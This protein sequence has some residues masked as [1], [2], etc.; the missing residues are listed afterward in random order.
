M[1]KTGLEKRKD[2]R[3]VNQEQKARNRRGQKKTWHKTLPD[4]PFW[5]S[6]NK[7]TVVLEDRVAGELVGGEKKKVGEGDNVLNFR[8]E[9]KISWAKIGKKEIGLRFSN[10][11][12]GGLSHVG[13]KGGGGGPNG[14]PGEWPDCPWVKLLRRV[15]FGSHA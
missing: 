12:S 15:V 13:K 6:L 8:K 5:R 1:I 14:P 4:R 2:V 10:I 7:R 9:Q 11:K 3:G